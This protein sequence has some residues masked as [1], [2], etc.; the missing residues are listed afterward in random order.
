MKRIRLKN[1]KGMTLV[2]IVAATA[3]MAIAFVA[4]ISLFTASSSTTSYNREKTDMMM[5]AQGLMEDTCNSALTIAGFNSL[6]LEG[7]GLEHDMS[8][9]MAQSYQDR[10]DAVRVITIVS[11]DTGS[12]LMKVTIRVK[13]KTERDYSSGVSLVTQ[14]SGL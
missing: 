6:S 14:V 8:E 5:A 2:E 11:S 12:N 4:L 7:D 3:I 9:H 1:R 10:Y 13:E